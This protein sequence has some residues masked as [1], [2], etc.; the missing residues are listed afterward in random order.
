[1]VRRWVNV[2][3]KIRIFSRQLAFFLKTTHNTLLPPREPIL[4]YQFESGSKPVQY[5]Y[6][7]SSKPDQNCPSKPVQYQFNT[8]SKPVQYQ[9]NTSSIPVS[10]Y[11]GWSLSNEVLLVSY[12][13]RQ[14][15]DTHGHSLQKGHSL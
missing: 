3:M 9:F 13:E 7:I 1:M 14:R 15:T 10:F 12:F 2:R 8:S 5:N 6:K 4:V 11:L